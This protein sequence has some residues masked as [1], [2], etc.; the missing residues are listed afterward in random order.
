MQKMQKEIEKMREEMKN[1][2]HEMNKETKKSK[3]VEI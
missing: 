3:S 2:K 1:L